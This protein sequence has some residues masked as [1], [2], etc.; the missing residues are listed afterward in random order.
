MWFPV[1]LALA[2][3]GTASYSE[4][5]TPCRS[6]TQKHKFEVSQGYPQGRKGY[7]VD[8]ICPLGCGGYDTPSNMQYQ[9]IKEA[10][11]KDKW[12]R[13]AKGCESLCTNQNSTYPVRNTFNCKSK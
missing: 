11:E 13:T 8:H 6:A 10:K 7:W 9:T 2:M 5:G 1:L 12:E 3:Y 4:A